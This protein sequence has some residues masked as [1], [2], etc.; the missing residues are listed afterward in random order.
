MTHKKFF[1]VVIGWKKGYSGVISWKEK[2]SMDE[3]RLMSEAKRDVVIGQ[4]FNLIFLQVSF[5]VPTSKSSKNHTFLLKF[6]A[7]L[8]PSLSIQ[9]N[10]IN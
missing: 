5:Q 8:F 4:F 10:R 7:H 6:K 1:D 9:S 3:F 2:Y